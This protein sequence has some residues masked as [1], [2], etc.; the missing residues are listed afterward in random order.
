M[1][2]FL[3]R[4][5]NTSA[6]G[7][8]MAQKQGR[9][10]AVISGMPASMQEIAA[11]AAKQDFQNRTAGI[12]RQAQADNAKYAAAGIGGIAKLYGTHQKSRE[13]DAKQ[14]DKLGAGVEGRTPD[15][16]YQALQAGGPQPSLGNPY[17][18]DF[19]PADPNDP[20]WQFLLGLEPNM[21]PYGMPPEGNY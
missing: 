9:R 14:R 18:A 21:L 3:T 4:F 1:S 7:Q 11:Q 19:G 5:D 12:E 10:S 16:H 15:Q 17:P 20:F 6:P 13:F 2:A 8:G